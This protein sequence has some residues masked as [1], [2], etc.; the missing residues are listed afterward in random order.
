MVVVVMILVIRAALVVASAAEQ[1]AKERTTCSADQGAFASP[2]ALIAHDGSYSGASGTT[3]GGAT[4]GT[5]SIT[6]HPR[7]RGEDRASNNNEF[8]FHRLF[9]SNRSSYAYRR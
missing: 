1:T 8:L 9:S 7:Q 4:F 5:R 3:N 6:G 2:A